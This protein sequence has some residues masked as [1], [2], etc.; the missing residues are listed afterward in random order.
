[1]KILSID[2]ST[3]NFSLAVSKDGRV[4]R[5][6]NIFLD[7]VLE[8]SIIPS[9]E[10]ILK[11]ADVRFKDLDGFA[12]G[13]GPGSFTSLRVGLSTIKSIRVGCQGR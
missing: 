2:T 8:S 1:M 9:I 10:G 3:K 5:Y 6:R 4:L 13:L 11:S 7:K 12:I